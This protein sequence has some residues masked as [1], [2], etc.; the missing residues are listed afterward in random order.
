MPS[1]ARTSPLRLSICIATFNR[2]EALRTT[3]QRVITQIASS[4]YHDVCEVVVCDNASSDDTGKLTLELGRCF[5]GLRYFRQEANIGWE[6]NFNSAVEA[7]CGEYCW[8]MPDDDLLK[9]GAVTAVLNALDRSP[10]LVVINAD[11]I[12]ADD[13]SIVLGRGLD[14]AADRIYEPQEMDRLFEEAGPQMRYVG[15]VVIK[16]SIWRERIAEKYYGSW[17]PQVA[18]VF[19][20]PLPDG[21]VVIAEALVSVTYGRQSWL[22]SSFE[23]FY[24]R[25]PLTVESLALSKVVKMRA[26]RLTR[27]FSSLLLMRARGLYSL[28]EYRKWIRPNFRSPRHR[29]I[30]LGVA[31]TPG[32]LV[33]T[34]V[35]G[36]YLAKYFLSR[37]KRIEAA[38]L[39][40][41]AGGCYYLGKP[42]L[43]GR[44][45]SSST[46]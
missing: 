41:C 1:T 30:P 14:F 12:D 16:R 13:N 23:I 4:N 37:T 43:R 46:S 25:W 9:D 40:L 10:S 11:F 17:F 31:L 24:Y 20:A 19:S 39:R 33:N 27:S 6:R 29:L 15:A 7:A 26:W 34:I 35:V 21:A 5:P 44:M 42:G 3:L 28:G 2:Q 8:L 36:Y 22:S 38:T 32:T 45:P 18:V